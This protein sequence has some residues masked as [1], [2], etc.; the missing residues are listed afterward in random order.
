MNVIVVFL[1][2][3]GLRLADVIMIL[4]PDELQP[5]V[6]K[7]SIEPNLKAG[8]ALVFAH[9]FNIHFN[10]IVPPADVDKSDRSHVVL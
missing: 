2:P 10:Q 3:L 8:N 4:T 7:E 6:Y 9:G 1:R 5:K